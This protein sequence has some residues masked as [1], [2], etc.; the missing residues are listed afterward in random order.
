MQ[1]DN[2]VFFDWIPAFAGMTTGEAGMTMREAGMTTGEAGMTRDSGIGS[3]FVRHAGLVPASSGILCRLKGDSL[4]DWIPACAG[5]TT[6]YAGMT[7]RF[8]CL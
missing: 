6:Q 2:E 7:W 3:P 8:T 1:N 4:Y 5:M